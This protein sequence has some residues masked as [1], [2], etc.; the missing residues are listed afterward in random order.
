MLNCYNITH[1]Q[2]S[3]IHT[4]LH[5]YLSSQAL[6]A[7]Q[8][9][10]PSLLSSQSKLSCFHPPHG[11]GRLAASHWLL[12]LAWLFSACLTHILLL[13]AAP[14]FD[15]Y[16]SH[17]YRSLLHSVSIML[18]GDTYTNNFSFSL[19][20]FQSQLTFTHTFTQF[21]I[22]TGGLRGLAGPTVVCWAQ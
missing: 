4:L 21:L 11:I 10:I 12:G 15:T 22:H 2:N 1:Y 17:R 20:S 16:K 9:M 5:T 19:S 18:Q 8:R 7:P 3:S 13:I 14:K 6:A